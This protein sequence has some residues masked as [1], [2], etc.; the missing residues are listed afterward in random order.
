MAFVMVI[1]VFMISVDA[2]ATYKS[3]WTLNAQLG[4]ST[5]GSSNTINVK[6]GDTVKVT[7]RL[8]NNYYT[9]STCFQLY[10]SSDIF[11]GATDAQFN[12]N[13]KFYSVCGKSNST[14]VDWNELHPEVQSTYWPNFSAEKLKSYKQNHHFL[15]VTMIPNPAKT[16]T[17]VKDFNED[18][19]TITFKVS[20]SAKNGTMGEITLPIESARSK[21]FANGFLFSTIFKTEE[22]LGDYMIYSDDQV[23]DCS[24]ATLKFKVSTSSSDSSLGDVDENGS[25][26]SVDA[27][28]VLQHSVG[29]KTL[30]AEQKKRADVTK[31]GN[32]NSQDALKILQF[33]VG[34][35]TKF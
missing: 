23:F 34:A 13:G 35:I 24:K 1:S 22:L 30:T 2:K 20:S 9:G 6:P 33:S 31:D 18:I 25:I 5:Y 27:L 21:S 3:V 11:E 10:Y 17:T 4:S 32:I 7:V 8:A 12:T 14:F 16:T 15:R 26:N 19:V 29:S 28:L